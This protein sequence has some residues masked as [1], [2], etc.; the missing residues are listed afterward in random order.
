[1]ENTKK[2]IKTKLAEMLLNPIYEKQLD[3]NLKLSVVM[4]PN[5]N[6]IEYKKGRYGHN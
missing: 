5:M 6:L 2:T 1:M 3:D 4:K